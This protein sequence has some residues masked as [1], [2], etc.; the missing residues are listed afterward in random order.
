MR[1]EGR[2][3][4]EIYMD[5]VAAPPIPRLLP[6]ALNGHR[7]G[8][9]R[10][11]G[12]CS[13]QVREG[14]IQEDLISSIVQGRGYANPTYGAASEGASARLQTLPEITAHTDATQLVSHR[15]LSREPTQLSSELCVF[16]SSTACE[17]PA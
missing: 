1:S 6:F 11:D 2:L 3:P 17:V 14:A 5:E 12:T 16:R 10:P 13:D 15:E 7:E 4:R 9:C 8:H